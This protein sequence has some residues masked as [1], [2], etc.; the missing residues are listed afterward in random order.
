[1]QPLRTQIWDIWIQDRTA[2]SQNLQAT[3]R[4]QIFSPLY[5]HLEIKTIRLVILDESFVALL[6][7]S[8][9]V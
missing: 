1:M 8:K 6:M 7:L 3:L 4:A 5:V 9:T 2:H